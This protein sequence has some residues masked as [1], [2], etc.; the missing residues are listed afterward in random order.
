MEEVS[1]I[2]SGYQ[3]GSGVTSTSGRRNGS[4]TTG[5]G[6]AADPLPSP[7]GKLASIVFL[8]NDALY[9]TMYRR[10]GAVSNSDAMTT[11][12]GGDDNGR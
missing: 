5:T 2:V 8:D 1:W 10:R 3:R 7:L 6:G 11:M 4:K 9:W 12:G